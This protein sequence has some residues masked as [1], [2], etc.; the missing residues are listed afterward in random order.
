MKHL[1]NITKVL[2]LTIFLSGMALQV[3][4]QRPDGAF[5]AISAAIQAGDANAL[6]QHFNNNVEVTLPDVDQSFSAQQA[7]F[8]LKDFFAKHTV[9]KYTVNHK[10]TSGSTHYQ[11]GTCTT[12]EL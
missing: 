5:K 8:V 6:A 2:L 3:Q 1:Y 11:T 7:T 9:G 10:G 4:A 12:R